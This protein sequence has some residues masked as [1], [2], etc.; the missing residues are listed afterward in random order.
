LRRLSPARGHNNEI[1]LK[2]EWFD[3]RLNASM[4]LFKSRQD[5]LAEY[6]FFDAVNG[7]SIYRG[8]D[9]HAR[10]VELEVA[11]ELAEGVKLSAGYSR[12]GI[13]NGAGDDVRTFVPRKTLRL[14]GTWQVMPKL[15]LGAKLNWR[16]R[17]WIDQ[18]AG[19]TTAQSAYALIDLMARY[20]ID[21]RWSASFNLNNL[22]NEKYL[23]S[24][25]WKQ[26]YYGA[27]R[28]LNVSLNWKY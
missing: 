12:L 25:Y 19:V 20:D 8:V 13:E 24:L 26:A 9:T 27:P 17:T 2:G 6:A 7:V 1:G 28:S 11:G 18:G 4:A 22:T 16:S 14:A 21:K 23:N 5:N 3:R 15:K 10:G